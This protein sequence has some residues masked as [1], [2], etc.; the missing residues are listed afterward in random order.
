MAIGGAVGFL[1]AAAVLIIRMLMDRTLKTEEDV[2][3]YLQLP[4]LSAVPY[5]NE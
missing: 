3:K 5:F 2:E 1:L 4:V